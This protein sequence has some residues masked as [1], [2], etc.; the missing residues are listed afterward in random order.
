[1][2]VLA[3]DLLRLSVLPDGPSMPHTIRL[4]IDVFNNEDREERVDS[5]IMDQLRGM[6]V[7]QMLRPMQFAPVP[8]S[9][10]VMMAFTITTLN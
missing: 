9:G 6:T 10:L 7:L 2:L 8:N 1:V 5:V 4:P 3:H